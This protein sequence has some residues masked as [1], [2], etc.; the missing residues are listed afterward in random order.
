MNNHAGHASDNKSAASAARLAQLCARYF[1]ASPS[2]VDVTD[3]RSLLNISPGPLSDSKVVAALAQRIRE[4]TVSPDSASL[5]A[6]E[7]RFAL[8]AAASKLFTRTSGAPVAGPAGEAEESGDSAHRAS[9][10]NQAQ[11]IIHIC[12]GLT[13]Q[14]MIKLTSLG[15]EHGLDGLELAA[16]VTESS[17]RGRPTSAAGGA[18]Y[19]DDAPPEPRQR[20]SGAEPRPRSIL[21]PPRRDVSTDFDQA[22]AS[23]RST[24]KVSKGIALVLGGLATLLC[25]AAAILTILVRGGAA[26]PPSTS[27]N[28]TPTA[29]PVQSA[30]TAS[31]VIPP[32]RPSPEQAVAS[33][34]PEPR[35]A[36]APTSVKTGADKQGTSSRPITNP[37]E[38]AREWNDLAREAERVTTA[39]RNLQPDA[40]PRFI[41]VFN[42]MAGDWTH[43]SP[44]QIT[45]AVR[46][47]TD[48]VY[49]SAG[50][51]EQLRLCI[52]EVTRAV[53]GPATPTIPDPGQVHS[54]IFASGLTSRLA[55]E[56]DLPREITEL[57]AAANERVTRGGGD[58]TFQSGARAQLRSLL[59][60][61][62]PAAAQLQEARTKASLDAWAAWLS[63]ARALNPSPVIVAFDGTKVDAANSL[64]SPPPPPVAP[65]LFQTSVIAA[66]DRLLTLPPLIATDESVVGSIALLT[67]AMAW[68]EGDT[69]RTWLLAQFDNP[70]VSALG[71]RT[72]TSSLA[73]K[74][75][76]PGV[77]ITMVLSANAN[78]SA[79]AE[80]RDRYALA[81]SVTGNAS[82]RDIEIQW[83]EAALAE[84]AKGDKR[85]EL[86]QSAATAVAMAKLSQAAFL[87]TAP[88]GDTGANELEA[89]NLI[90]SYNVGFDQLV[91][92]ATT[93]VVRPILSDELT[94][95]GLA[96]LSSGAKIPERLSLLAQAPLVP[97]MAEARILIE[98][99]CR[100]GPARV[101]IEAINL[102]RRMSTFP[103]VAVAMLD[104]APFI[105]ATSDNSDLVRMVTGSTSIPSVR[106]AS[107]RVAVRRALVERVMEV[108]SGNGPGALADAVAESLA[109]S[110]VSVTT[111]LGG[112]GTATGQQTSSGAVPAGGM[113]QTNVAPE[114]ACDRAADALLLAA[115]KYL[116]T[117]REPQSLSVIV[118]RR[119]A[120]ERLC[121]EGAGV[122]S[123]GTNQIHKFIA[124]QTT[125]AETF[126]YIVACERPTSAAVIGTLLTS[127]R[128][129]SQQAT[130][131]FEQLYVNERLLLELWCVRM[132]LPLPYLGEVAPSPEASTQ[133]GDAEKARVK[134]GQGS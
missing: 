16:M 103:S 33:G 50:Q 7:L 92:R 18:W 5:E 22:A 113:A 14:A 83:R 17:G 110:Y 90:S 65:N 77:D 112:S 52:D 95:W 117:G 15:A 1:P 46:S 118:A 96:Y 109:I 100:G 3:P 120:R 19:A 67:V 36:A 54:M 102:V 132:N 82:R 60:R 85:P 94:P 84:L 20:G 91:T 80:L 133:A 32:P 98:Q 28:A 35:N 126:A 101:Q 10:I 114:L 63:A 129:Q 106:D 107:W 89:K 8:H 13:P 12:G 61:L 23:S 43:A 49:A 48:A 66:L 47:L 34:S 131:C 30:V 69:S 9:L 115:R 58:T 105:H 64:L 41:E 125:V 31:T 123:T 51:P 68:R 4:V 70:A 75:G 45:D 76:A 42:Q 56:R 24:R 37:P 122:G 99:A 78:L 104:F 87:L 2:G 62:V 26:A 71:L 79:R 73:N 86:Y 97:T 44:D 27:A 11:L 55:R 59:D 124:A 111:A 130:H 6:D 119:A 57:V 121:E 116:P 127:A 88:A 72:L 25:V 134:G 108:V 81:W 93:G 74:S 38:R 128:D 40:L 39:F 29:P 53:D 21:D